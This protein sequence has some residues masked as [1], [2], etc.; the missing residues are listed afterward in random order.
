MEQITRLQKSRNAYKGHV[1]RQFK[2]VEELMATE[3]IDQLVLSSLKTTQELLMKKKETI[4]QLD[5]QIIEL[6]VDADVLEEAILE[7]EDTQDRILEKV[8]LIDTFIRMHLRT[9]TPDSLT[10]S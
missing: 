9:H 4:H 7:T 5:T 6:I 2:K 1:A 8:N 3:K 10:A